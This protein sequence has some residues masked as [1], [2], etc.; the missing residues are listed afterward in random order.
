MRRFGA[1]GAGAGVQGLGVLEWEEQRPEGRWG[2]VYGGGG[3]RW[4]KSKGCDGRTEQGT[5]RGLGFVP[6]VERLGG[7]GGKKQLD[8]EQCAF[9]IILYLCDKNTFI[10]FP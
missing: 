7:A 1:T 2:V 4:H 5:R 3:L 10:F 9:P 6:G 8:S